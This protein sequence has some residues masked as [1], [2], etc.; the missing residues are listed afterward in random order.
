MLYVSG[1]KMIEGLGVVYKRG[2]GVWGLKFRGEQ[3]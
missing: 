1:I 3:V 2:L